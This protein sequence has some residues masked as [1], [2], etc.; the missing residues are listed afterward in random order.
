MT[1]FWYDRSGRAVY[2]AAGITLPRTATHDSIL[3]AG[4]YLCA[5]GRDLSDPTQLQAAVF[6]YNLADHRSTTHRRPDIDGTV[7]RLL[8]H[9]PGH[10]PQLSSHDRI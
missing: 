10:R 3:A 4:N 6:G 8:T 5:G 9:V 1:C 2:G 7:S